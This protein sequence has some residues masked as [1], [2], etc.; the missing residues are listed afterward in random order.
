MTRKILFAAAV[1]G[2][3][4]F[5]ANCSFTPPR[6][7]SDEPDW[8]TFF[9]GCFEGSI[10][11][12]PDGKPLKIVLVAGPN[13]EFT[14]IG[15]IRISADV[16]ET[17]AGQVEDAGE[18]NLARLTVTRMDGSTYRVLAERQ[19]IGEVGATSVNLSN[20]TNAPF[21]RGD[22]LT[23]CASLILQSCPDLTITLPFMPGGGK[24]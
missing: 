3:T 20:E 13:D 16:P 6:I 21:E 15:C 17:L 23:R 7:G 18:H 12:P 9:A 8:N 5:W 1:L 22:N 10:T 4:I 19:P 11:D 2:A 14:L 24:P